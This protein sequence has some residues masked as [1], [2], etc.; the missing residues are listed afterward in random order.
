MKSISL[1]RQNDIVC[2]LKQGRSTRAIAASHGVSKGTI[3]RVKGKFRVKC[4]KKPAGRPKK[5][6]KA[7]ERRL[8]QAVETGVC[9]D[10]VSAHKSLP[11]ASRNVISRKTIARTLQR[12]GLRAHIKQKKPMLTARHRKL[13]LAFA[14]AHQHWTVEDWKKVWFSD[15]TKLNLFGSDGKDYYW[16]KPGSAARKHHFQPTLKHGGGSI[17]LWGVLTPNG[18]GK[19]TQ[20]HGKMDAAMYCGILAKFL[21]LQEQRE[22]KKPGEY[23]FQQDN[24]PKHTSRLAKTHF[25]RRGLTVLPWPPNSPDLNIIEHCWNELKR[26][27]YRRSRH[28]STL[29]ALVDAAKGEWVDV[30][31]DFV[32]TLYE[33]MPRRM[34]AVMKAKG[35][36]TKY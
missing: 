14:R 22:G 26:R 6:S 4:A 25:E 5:L 11:T 30:E 32:E 24:D 12:H 16:K 18:A 23:I 27:I 15:E 20:I 10:A 19:I 28:P 29:G 13:R 35:G 3:T 31:Q 7:S 34:A 1:D 21:R 36:N 33:S 17:M 2:A 9:S 8:V